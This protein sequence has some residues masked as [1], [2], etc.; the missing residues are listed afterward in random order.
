VLLVAD[1]VL[2]VRVAL[3]VTAKAVRVALL[4]VDGANLSPEKALRE[5]AAVGEGNR[6]PLAMVPLLLS[7]ATISRCAARLAVNCKMFISSFP[8]FA[9]PIDLHFSYQS[10]WR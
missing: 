5:L 6:T 8:G 9:Q 4:V 7:S 2:A 10:I 3:L 1:G